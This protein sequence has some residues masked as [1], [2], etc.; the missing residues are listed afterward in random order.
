MQMVYSGVYKLAPDSIYK[1][2]LHVF[3][4]SDSVSYS[5]FMQLHLSSLSDNSICIS[6]HHIKIL[7]LF[8]LKNKIQFSLNCMAV[9]KGSARMIYSWLCH[10]QGAFVEN[11]MECVTAPLL[12]SVWMIER[13]LAVKWTLENVSWFLS[14]VPAVFIFPVIQ[15]RMSFHCE[16][17]GSVNKGT[18]I[19]APLWQLPPLTL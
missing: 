4:C 1:H 16:F 18:L 19:E 13:G 17:V 3:F 11:M 2:L 14:E 9:V 10:F 15:W 8:F 5:F 7:S 12:K 6:I